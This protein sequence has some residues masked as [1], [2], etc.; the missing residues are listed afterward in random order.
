MRR[1]T[2]ARD[3]STA[4]ALG[5]NLP[6]YRAIDILGSLTEAAYQAGIPL[7]N[8]S[9]YRKGALVTPEAAAQALERATDGQIKADDILKANKRI[10]A[11]RLL[12]RAEQLLREAA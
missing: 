3:E 5:Y 10:E 7:A 8:L 2:R 12:D 6:V 9:K 1:H 11:A 4:A